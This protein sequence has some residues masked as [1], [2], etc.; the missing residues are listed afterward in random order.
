[1]T[2]P[3]VYYFSNLPAKLP[4]ELPS[5]DFPMVVISRRLIRE[6]IYIV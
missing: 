2:H 4:K 1:M 5:I 6:L 3:N